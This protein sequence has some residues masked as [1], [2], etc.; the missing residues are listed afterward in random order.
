VLSGCSDS[1]D[2]PESSDNQN[3]AQRVGAAGT[4]ADDTLRILDSIYNNRR[5]PD[6]FYSETQPD[7][8]VYQSINQI[9]N[10][11]VMAPAD[12]N[13]DTPRFELCADD[14]SQALDW[15][16]TASSGLG[17]L[18][19]NSEDILFYQFSYT[20]PATPQQSN[21]QRV[22]KCS[23]IDRSAL[24]IREPDGQ[25][26]RYTEIVQNPDRIKL[27]IEYL[28]T[29][30]EYNNYGNAILSSNISDAGDVYQHDM[31]H[32]RLIPAVNS[33]AECDTVE[34][35]RV[36]YRID[37]ISGEITVTES[38]LNTIRSR[39]ENGNME[40]CEDE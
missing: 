14:F 20:P 33:V 6:G 15:S 10:I 36:R 16:L 9:K 31:E 23:V 34:L 39:Y 21:L 27:L 8:G 5:T 1:S 12:Y 13:D 26:G 7:P 24:D 35:Y 30:S 18:V 19:D 28:W 37:K 4:G 29:F 22:F 25:L 2:K 11:N 38:L 17:N 40:V 3:T 32:A